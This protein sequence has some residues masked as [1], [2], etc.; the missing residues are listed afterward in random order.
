MLEYM[1]YSSV[2]S[3][4]SLSTNLFIF[5]E[6]NFLDK[7]LAMSK[8]VKVVSLWTVVTTGG[9]SVSYVPLPGFFNPLFLAGLSV[10]EFF[11]TLS[12]QQLHKVRPFRFHH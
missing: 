5:S 3:I 8:V 4:A 7:F 6:T 11:L 1:E 9:L 2:Q 12:H 10:F